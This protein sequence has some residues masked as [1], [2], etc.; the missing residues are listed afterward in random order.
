M[1]KFDKD[2]INALKKLESAG[3]ATYASGDCV[4]EYVSGGTPLDWDL[5]TEAP[6]EKIQEIFPEG[7]CIDPERGVIRLD[8]THEVETEDGSEIEGAICDVIPYEGT[9]EDLLAKRAFTI[10]AVADSPERG[11]ADPYNGVDDIHKKLLRSIGDADEAFAADPI[12]MMQAMRYVAELGFDL[13][14]NVHDAILRNWRKLQNV[15][16]EQVRD[17]LELIICGKS[18]GKA[19]NMMAD[20][21]LMAVVFGEE[22]SRK[23]SASEMQQFIEVTKNIDKTMPVRLRRLGLLYTT[24][25]QKRGLEA[26]KYMHF[27]VDTEAH[28]TWALTELVKVTFLANGT[29]LKRYIY[30]NG[31]EKYNYLHNLTKA[32]RIVYDQSSIKIEARNAIMREIKRN[33]EPIFL[34]DLV[35]DANDILEEGITDDPE[36]AE[37]LLEQVIAKVHINPANNERSVLLKL[38]KKYN[39]SKFRA[40]TRYVNWMR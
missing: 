38:A 6:M 4:I 10:S 14:K 24:L 17:E 25:N 20:T 34:D 11:L 1:L 30:E 22:V 40:A 28:L 32:Q 18:A 27:D 26:V 16:I 13:T 7:T 12:R 37:H 19:L 31:S 39:K 33:H 3:F 23:M 8:F 21:G 2:V 15:P 9:I 5:L 29:E 35:I 36:R